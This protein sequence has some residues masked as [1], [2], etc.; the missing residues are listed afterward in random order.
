MAE[1]GKDVLS[2]VGKR[3]EEGAAEGK[4]GTEQENR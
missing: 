1:R 3:E 4:G 2:I